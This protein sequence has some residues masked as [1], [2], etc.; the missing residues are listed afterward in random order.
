MHSDNSSEVVIYRTRTG[1]SMGGET[2]QDKC[3]RFFRSLLISHVSR[4]KS[5]YD[6]M[7]LLLINISTVFLLYK[8]VFYPDYYYFID[9]I[10]PYIEIL[11]FIYIILNFFQKYKD[12]KTG[13]I[14]ASYRKI[15]LKYLL[16]WFIIDFLSIFPFKLFLSRYKFYI[17]YKLIRIIRLPKLLQ[18]ISFYKLKQ[19]AKAFLLSNPRKKYK[20]YHKITQTVKLFWLIAIS[21]L[22]TYILTCTW[23]WACKE[24]EK[25]ETQSFII[26]YEL[27]GARPFDKLLISFYFVLTILTTAGFGDYVP[28]SIY[29]QVIALFFMIFGAFGFS[30]FIAVMSEASQ[31]IE[32]Q[33][34]QLQKCYREINEKIN[35]R[36]IKKI[37]K[38][39][40]YYVKKDVNCFVD[41]NNYVINS[42]PLHLKEKIFNFYWKEFYE[43]FYTIFCFYGKNVKKFFNFYYEISFYYYP[44]YFEKNCLIFETNQNI[45]EILFI[46]DGIVNIKDKINVITTATFKDILGIYFCLFD[47]TPIYDYQAATNVEILGINKN[48]FCEK[49]NNYP[50]LKEKIK[51]YSL[52]KREQY[53]NLHKISNRQSQRF[54]GHSVNFRTKKTVELSQLSGESAKFGEK[55]KKLRKDIRALEDNNLNVM[56]Y[57]YLSHFDL[58]NEI[59]AKKYAIFL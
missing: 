38:Q 21:I 23:Y 39:V 4:W 31:E 32:D 34:L 33:T 20:D 51:N 11:F 55:L 1:I 49:L 50:E 58:E 14:V 59:A 48:I 46:K 47:I 52:K 19:I 41:N 22:V 17:Y 40:T 24:I 7:V 25:I 28:I 37:D 43:N 2:I 15:A 9:N 35:K 57:I 18:M 56:K 36:L 45:Y 54:F 12:K 29:E 53:Y 3:K 6:F 13:K 27:R 26:K 10:N 42:L 5:I 8:F 16:G 30:Y 44:R